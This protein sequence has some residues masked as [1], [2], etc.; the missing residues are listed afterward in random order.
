MGRYSFN[1]IQPVFL[2]PVENDI[3]KLVVLRD[4]HPNCRQRFSVAHDA[5]A[6]RNSEIKYCRAR[7]ETRTELLDDRHLKNVVLPGES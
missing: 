3:R 1:Q 4:R 7:R 5:F 6:R 2:A